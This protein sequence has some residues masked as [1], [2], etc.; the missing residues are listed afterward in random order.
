MPLWTPR[1][2]EGPKR[3]N[4]RFRP[5]PSH[6]LR[7]GINGHIR[8]RL[9]RDGVI[10]G[11]AHDGE[12]L[13]SH[14][15]TNAE[16]ALAANYAPGDIVAFHRDYRSLGVE[17]G[18]ERRVARVDAG[19]GAVFLEGLEGEVAWRPRMT[20]AKRGGVE[21]YRAEGIELRAGDRIRWTRNDVGLGLVNSGTAEIAAVRDGRVSFRLEDGRMMELGSQDPQLRHLDHAWAAT[22]HGFQGRTVD[23]VIAVAEARHPHLTTL[24]S[25]YVEISRARHDAELVTDDAKALRETLEAVTGERIAALEAVEPAIDKAAAKED[26]RDRGVAPALERMPDE[27]DTGRQSAKEAHE[28]HAREAEPQKVRERGVEIEM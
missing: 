3:R 27:T 17:K 15:Y 5:T 13:V 28:P 10:H 19:I 7:R 4:P 2:V 26:G 23:H 25:F 6:E 16:K 20:G 11:P 14:G 12:R 22:V 21:V 8:E 1:E 9:A 24:K 18:D